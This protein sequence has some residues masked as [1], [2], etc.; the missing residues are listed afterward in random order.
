MTGVDTALL[1]GLL[2]ALAVSAGHWR[3]WGWLLAATVSYA[4]STLYWRSDLPYGAFIAGLCDAAICLAVYF[5]AKYRWELWVWRLFQV[6]VGV[7]IWYLAAQHGMAPYLSHGIYSV[8][9]ETIN[10][11]ALIFLGGTGFFQPVGGQDASAAD[12]RLG[13]RI[14]RALSPLYRARTHAPLHKAGR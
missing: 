3:T 9:L 1:A 6:S 5:L 7:N 10:W 4:V 2:V 11:T 14:R 13:P 12:G 8:I